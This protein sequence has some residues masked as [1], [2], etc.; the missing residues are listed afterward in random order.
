MYG[1][2]LL[3]LRVMRVYVRGVPGLLQ[4]PLLGLQRLD[5]VAELVEG[6][7][8]VAVLRVVGAAGLVVDVQRLGTLAL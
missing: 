2:Y 6:A 8:D 1:N 3:S 5:A 7:A 4:L